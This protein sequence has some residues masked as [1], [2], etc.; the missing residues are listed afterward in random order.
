MRVVEDHWEERRVA[1]SEKGVKF[2]HIEIFQ[3]VCTERSHSL[4]SSEVAVETSCERRKYTL[5]R[6]DPYFDSNLRSF[7]RKFILGAWVAFIS[8]ISR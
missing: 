3:G 4:V 5:T 7:V 1:D 8:P 6:N 2:V